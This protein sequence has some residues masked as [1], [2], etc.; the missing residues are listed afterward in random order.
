MA[1]D[2]IQNGEKRHGWLAVFFL[3]TAAAALV[4]CSTDTADTL[5]R[6]RGGDPV[7]VGYANEAPYAYLD[8]EKNELTGEA[9]EIARVVLG[10]LELGKI[11]GVLTEFGSLIPGLQ[12]GRFD[13]IAASMYITPARCEQIAFSEPTYCMGEAFAVLASNPLGL[14][15]YEDVASH[16]TARLGIVAG[17]VEL[18]YARAQGVPD[19]RIVIFPDNPSA[20]E[21]VLASRVDAFAG[22]RSTVQN[23]LQTAANDR[24]EM[25]EPFTD[26]VIDGQPVR[27]CGAFGFRSQDA[28]LLQAFNE[29]LSE[30]IGSPEHLETVAPFGLTEKDM[31]HGITTGDLCQPAP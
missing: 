25:A 23:L 4:A 18:G 30:Y 14:N 22:T 2:R 12:A 15:S 17:T 11:E 16:A 19:E 27:G 3:V 5:E 29:G 10:Q 26:P 8:N 21:G 13:M 20:L 7:R 1:E 24:L 31:P 6:L 28:A 9:P